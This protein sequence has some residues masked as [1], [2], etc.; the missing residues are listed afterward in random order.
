[1]T[2]EQ[3]LLGREARETVALALDAL[4]PEAREVVVLR[5]VEGLTAAEVA[6]VTGVSVAAVKSRLHRARTALREH[7][8][9]WWAAS[10]PKQPGHPARMSSPCCRRSWKT[11]SAPRCAPKWKST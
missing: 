9:L 5:D 3:A 2:P 1:M 7:C 10:R 11:R 6:E 4:D 8:W